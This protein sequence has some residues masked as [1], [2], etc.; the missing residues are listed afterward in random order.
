MDSFVDPHLIWRSLTEADWEEVAQLQTQIAVI[1]D[2]LLSTATDL[3]ES[4]P[5]GAERGE[6]IGGWDDYGSLS[7]FAWNFADPDE[8]PPVVHL[9]GAVHPTHRHQGIGANLLQWQVE[10]AVLWRDRTHPGEQLRLRCVVEGHPGLERMLLHRGF[11]VIRCLVDMVRPLHPLPAPVCPAGVEFVPFAPELSDVVLD[12]HR[13]CFEAP[14][15]RQTWEES[16]ASESFRP[17]WSVIAL[18]EGQVIGY[19]LNACVPT[20]DGEAEQGW[21]D[22]LGVTP[23]ER[24]HG[25]AEAMLVRSMQAMA[26]DGIESCGISVDVPSR[27]IAGW[28]TRT[29]GYE[30][31]DSVVT[32]ERVIA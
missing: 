22:R 11:T 27:T 23:Q 17:T 12:L 32:L 14:F 10:H 13:V 30:E 2:P 19:C 31:T 7:A 15:P 26:A 16:L 29:L 28:L 18:R 5:P 9:F 25:I 4:L 1:D 20:I 8:E 21:C 6:A 24:R 3:L